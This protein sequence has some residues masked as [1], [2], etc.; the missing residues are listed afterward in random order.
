MDEPE[1]KEKCQRHARGTRGLFHVAMSVEQMNKSNKN[2]SRRAPLVQLSSDSEKGLS[3]NPASRKP[4]SVVC[5]KTSLH[6]CHTHVVRRDGGSS[7][8][9]IFHSFVFE[10]GLRMT[11]LNRFSLKRVQLISCVSIGTNRLIRGGR[12]VSPLLSQF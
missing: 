4:V 12:N 9:C 8:V 6:R 10:A 5:S 11:A 2:G 3:E 7:L 1:E